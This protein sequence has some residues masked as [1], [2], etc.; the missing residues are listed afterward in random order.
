MKEQWKKIPNWPYEVSNKG[1]IY[2]QREENYLS[3]IGNRVVFCVNGEKEAFIV[4][5]L[6]AEAFLPNPD[7]LP[8]VENIDNDKGNNDVR[9]LRWV[10]DW[11]HDK[12]N[13]VEKI[14]DTTAKRCGVIYCYGP[15]GQYYECRSFREAADK[16][17]VHRNTIDYAT[18]NGT[19]PHGWR[20]ER[21]APV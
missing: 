8:F 3:T 9:N 7:N 19:T 1:R 5:R 20:F 18:K 21:S 17:G 15:K 10:K 6:V 16:T 14:R 2:S 11:Q 4:S 12:E 13:I